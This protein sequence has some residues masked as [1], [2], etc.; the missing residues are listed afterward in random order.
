M[1]AP[2]LIS[3]HT[4]HTDPH[5]R[6]APILANGHRHFTWPL[7]GG[8][9][10]TW[11]RMIFTDA[12]HGPPGRVAPLPLSTLECV[13]RLCANGWLE[14]SSERRPSSPSSAR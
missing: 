8:G 4:G 5:H 6:Y 2:E 3:G 9:F 1:C 12:N 13:M 11:H 7:D 14:S 10:R